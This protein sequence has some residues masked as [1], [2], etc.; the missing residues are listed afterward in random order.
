[1]ARN[2]MCILCSVLSFIMWAGITQS[3]KRLDTGWTVRGS[4]S[5]GGE[6]FRTC[7]DRPC[8]PT[9]LPYNEYRVFSVGKVAGAWR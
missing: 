3:V 7:P 6:I 9:N 4:N 5:G 8:G 1:M 2:R